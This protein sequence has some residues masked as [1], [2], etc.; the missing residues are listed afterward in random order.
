MRTSF[1]QDQKQILS[2]TPYALDEQS[3]GTL[4]RTRKPKKAK[5]LKEFKRSLMKFD[6]DKMNLETILTTTK[7]RDIGYEHV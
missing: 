5:T 2:G 1:F 6:I 3:H 4:E 7:N